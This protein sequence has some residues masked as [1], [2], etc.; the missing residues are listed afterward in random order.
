MQQNF[1]D[2]NFQILFVEDVIAAASSATASEASLVVLQ[3]PA[4]NTWSPILG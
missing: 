4:A 1:V 2:F 3:Q